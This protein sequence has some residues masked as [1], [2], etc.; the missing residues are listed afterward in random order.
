MAFGRE[1]SFIFRSCELDFEGSLCSYIAN[2]GRFYGEFSLW[3]IERHKK[4]E[5][6]EL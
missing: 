4:L 3:S 2:P 6:I 1:I 5:F